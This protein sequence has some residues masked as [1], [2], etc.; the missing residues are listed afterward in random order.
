MD[1]NKL[2]QKAQEALQQAQVTAMEY[3]HSEIDAEH[4]LLT[5]LQQEHGLVPRL[6][7]RV[8]A[9]VATLLARIEE[10]LQGRARAT[11][12]EASFTRT[13]SREGRASSQASAR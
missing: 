3:G 6:I 1:M 10:E 12:D 11:G 5:L 4:V 9:S 7:E 8:G 2:T 13:S